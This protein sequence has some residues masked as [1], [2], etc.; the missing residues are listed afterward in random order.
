M[1]KLRFLVGDK[2][3]SCKVGTMIPKE[4]KY[5]EFLGCDE[6]PS[7]AYLS[8]MPKEKDILEEQANRLLGEKPL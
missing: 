2:C 7:C 6:F 3:P 8:S 5:G 1:K 4:G